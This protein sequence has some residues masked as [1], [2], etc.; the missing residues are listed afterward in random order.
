M[1]NQ[2]GITLI[3][4]ILYMILLIIIISI[5]S[6]VSQMFFSNIKA[7]TERG[8]YVSEFNKFNMYFVED[9]KNNKDIIEIQ[10]SKIILEDGTI[11]TFAGNSIY[12][13]KVKICQNITQCN[14]SK[15]EIESA[16]ITK[17]IIKV[18]MLIKGSQQLKTSNEY[19]LRYW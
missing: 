7:V 10:K 13:N 1:R 14:F 6:F 12:R 8:K 3:T 11:Y 16:G 2:K 18:E 15:Q 19:V 4:L 17:K 9:I 5:L